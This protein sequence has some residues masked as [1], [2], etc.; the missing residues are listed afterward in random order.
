MTTIEEYRKVEAEFE[1]RT[2]CLCECIP[3]V[4]CDCSKCPAQKQCKWLCA[5]DPF[6]K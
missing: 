5:N 2:D 1:A 6:R 3:P 4:S